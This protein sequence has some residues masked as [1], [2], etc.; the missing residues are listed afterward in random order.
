MNYLMILSGFVLLILGGNWLLKAAVS[1]SLRMKVPKIVIGMT[2]VSFATSAPELIVSLKAALDGH[3]DIS[4]GNIIGSNIANLG[5][6][7]GI[8]ITV[9]SIKVEKGFYTTDWPIMMLSSIV[10]YAVL[11]LD[12]QIVR[13]EGIMMFILLILVLIYLFRF[14]KKAVVEDFPG[15]T[16]LL[17]LGFT[18]L[19]FVIGGLGLWGGSEFLIKGAVNLANDF[20]VS[21]RVIGVTVISIGT[22]I[23]E[24]AAS[25]IAILKKEKAISLGNLLGS[26]V[27][28]I[29]AVLG[30]TSIVTPI[31]AFDQRLIDFDLIW[32]LIF[33]L[34]ILPLVFL[35]S[36]MTLSWK[37]G[38]ILLGA[39][40]V[41][42]AMLI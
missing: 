26:N 18:T 23:P 25:L 2:V 24:L 8:V 15:G 27:F 30:I 1:I 9:S 6:V 5:F 32:M 12:R 42:L 7:L 20:G 28:N 11:S 39:Y 36:R 29:L 40:T 16:Q 33:A 19:F 3:A 10:L 41:F 17:S 31:A 22:S 37:E 38:L 35:P 21:K 4:L 14:Q 13:W 34:L